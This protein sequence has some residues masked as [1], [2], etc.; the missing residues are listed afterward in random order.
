MLHPTINELTQ[1][2]KFNRYEIAL[3]T[4]KCAR[5]ITAEYMRQREQAERELAGV[6]DGDKSMVGMIDRELRDEKAVIVAIDKIYHGDYVIVRDESEQEPNQDSQYDFSSLAPETLA[7]PIVIQNDEDPE[8][9]K[10]YRFD[11]I[12]EE[13]EE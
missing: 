2:G 10:K 3:A 9:D 8:E 11:G 13:S 7:D 1:N 5:L 4:A 12:P 6:K